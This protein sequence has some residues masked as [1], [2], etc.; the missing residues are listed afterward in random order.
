M[1]IAA[2]QMRDVPIA[3]GADKTPIEIICCAWLTAERH[4]R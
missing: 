3:F 4:A 2:F 1:D